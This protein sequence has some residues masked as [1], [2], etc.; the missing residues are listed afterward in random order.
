M[1]FNGSDVYIIIKSTEKNKH[2]IKLMSIYDNCRA[3]NFRSRTDQG[4]FNRAKI[5]KDR[6]IYVKLRDYLQAAHG[7]EHL[8]AYGCWKLRKAVVDME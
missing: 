1:F 4:R 2:H 5:S 7:L 6:P 8:Q 3:Y